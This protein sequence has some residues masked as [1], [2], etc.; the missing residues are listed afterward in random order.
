MLNTFLATITDH[1]TS[2]LIGVLTLF[3]GLNGLLFDIRKNTELKNSFKNTSILGRFVI[4]TIFILGGVTI[5]KQILDKQDSTEVQKQLNKDLSEVQNKLLFAQ[6]QQ[7]KLTTITTNIDE[8][9]QST[10]KVTKET[11]GLANNIKLI[12]TITKDVTQDNKILLGRMNDSSL[13]S[14]EQQSQIIRFL[15]GLRLEQAKQGK[16][17]DE[18]ATESEIEVSQVSKFAHVTF[19]KLSVGENCEATASNS[20]EFYYD[21]YANGMRLLHPLH[22]IKSPLRLEDN[23]NSTEVNLGKINNLK[24]LG[25]EDIILFTGYVRERDPRNILLR[26]TYKYDGVFSKSIPVSQVS[27]VI[28]VIDEPDCNVKIHV[29]IGTSEKPLN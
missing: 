17:I 3:V 1:L 2:I 16:L 20:G 18:I 26:W 21:F 13:N 25:K 6:K 23:S 4:V 11:A 10:E 22:T 14:L 29:S 12:S 7:I 28:Q 15:E 9:T 19:D 24:I 5:Y 27:D 8:V